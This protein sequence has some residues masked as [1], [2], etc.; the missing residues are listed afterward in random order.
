MFAALIGA[1]C[2]STPLRRTQVIGLFVAF[3]GV[4]ILSWDSLSF[5]SGGAGLA[6]VAAIVASASYGLSVNFTK[7]RL[8]HVPPNVVSAGALTMASLIMI[9]PGLCLWPSEPPSVKASL[10][11]LLLAIVCTAAA[12]AIFFKLLTRSTA[13]STS[14]VTFLIPVF[15]ILWGAIVLGETVNSQLLVGMAVTLA[16][17]AL[18]IG[19]IGSDRRT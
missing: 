17:T 8:A 9:V 6:V 4:A 2:F 16:G 10:C 14:S 19:L 12:Y 3:A 15:A 11:V 18:V 13:T 1:L 5:K 7:H